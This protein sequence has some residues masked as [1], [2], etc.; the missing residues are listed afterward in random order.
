M[1]NGY[2]YISRPEDETPAQPRANDPFRRLVHL[3]MG[4]PKLD[5]L[6]VDKER[7]LIA[8]AQSSVPSRAAGAAVGKL[9]EH[10]LPLLRRI[11]NNCARNNNMTNRTDDL[12]SEA[13]AAFIQAIRRYDSINHD[14]RLAT[15]AAYAVSGATL[16]YAL[17]NR[18]AFAVG[19]SSADRVFLIGYNRFRAAFKIETGENFDVTRPE[20]VRRMADISNTNLKQFAAWWP[21]NAP[22]HRSP[23]RK[24]TSSIPPAPD[25]PRAR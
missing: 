5:M 20:H 7:E 25:S 1:T 21:S 6:D 13:V 8:L 11:T 14:A 15:F 18:H 19:T 22:A 12:L 24:S 16:T 17:A 23:Q 10:H 2:A 9:V 3:Y 4:R